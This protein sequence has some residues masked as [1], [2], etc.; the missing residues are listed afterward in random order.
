VSLGVDD[1]PRSVF[2]CLPL[3]EDIF[4]CLHDAVR[5]VVPVPVHAGEAS[6]R[7]W[8]QALP[9][10]PIHAGDLNVRDRRGRQFAGISIAACEAAAVNWLYQTPLSSLAFSAATSGSSILSIEKARRKVVAARLPLTS[11]IAVR[12]QPYREREP[13]PLL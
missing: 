8:L 12:L 4:W 9:H 1:L 6:L 13:E 10:P 11:V 7:H 2:P 5:S 3:S